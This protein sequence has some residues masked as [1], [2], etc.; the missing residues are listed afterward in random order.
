M[1][2]YSMNLAFLR[3]FTTFPLTDFS[4]RVSSI[5]LDIKPVAKLNYYLSEFIIYYDT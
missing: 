2:F 3:K 1:K 5:D 4:K